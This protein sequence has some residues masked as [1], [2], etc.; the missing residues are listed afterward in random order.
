M[1][2]LSV[3]HLIEILLVDNRVLECLFWFLVILHDTN[4]NQEVTLPIGTLNLLKI[5]LSL[6]LVI[7]L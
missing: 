2:S 7:Q 4:T 1:V 5:E 6:Q 3:L